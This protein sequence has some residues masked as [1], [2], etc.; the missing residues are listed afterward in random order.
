MLTHTVAKDKR[1]DDTTSFK[2][3]TLAKFSKKETTSIYIGRSSSTT[4]KDDLKTNPQSLW[5]EI[6]STLSLLAYVDVFYQRP[7]STRKQKI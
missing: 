3:N 7:H 1:K 2:T 6:K 4:R 5:T